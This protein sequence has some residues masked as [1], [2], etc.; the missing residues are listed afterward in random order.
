V[1]PT[2]W[3]EAGDWPNSNVIGVDPELRDPKHGDYR[4]RDGSPA[5]A[6]GCRVFPS[7]GSGSFVPAARDLAA[8]RPLT[9][10]RAGGRS[11]AT[12][13]GVVDAD[14]VWDA[15]T[16]RVMCDVVVEDGVTLEVAAGTR[17]EFQGCFGLDVHGRLL[18][19]G[20]PTEPVVF[21]TDE[22]DLYHPDTT[23]VGC[24]A[25]IRFDWTPA[26]NGLSRLE[27]CV[28]EYA[29]ALGDEPWGG[30]LSTTGFSGLV[31]RNTVVRRCWAE[32]G[33]AV[34]VSHHAAPV[35]VGCLF[36]D[37]AAHLYGSVAYSHYAY[38]RFVSCTMVGNSILS[39]NAYD[40]T[41]AVHNHIA[42]SRTVGCIVRDNPNPYY[43]PTEL[44]EAKAYYTTYSNVEAW[45]GGVG[46]L[47]TEP[48][49][50]R[51]G[52]HPYAILSGSP[53]EN[54][55]PPDTSGLWLPAVDLSGAPRIDAGRID[56][57]C[58][59]GDA[60][61]GVG[62]P[63]PDRPRIV[64]APNPFFERVELF[65]DAPQP[66]A[67][68]VRVYSVDG[69][70]VRTVLEGRVDAGPVRLS[71]DGSTDNGRPAASGIYFVR[72]A[73]AVGQRTGRIALLR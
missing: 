6:Y 23:A 61:T 66:G 21:T 53:C 51:F 20:A 52:P 42:K 25:G 15:D 28:L 40:A 27:H 67:A 31:V 71:W 58:Y 19:V 48:D 57:G 44:H 60:D 30:A 22:P 18:A 4:P 10:H 41:G 11:S 9:T 13:G 34:F 54:A 55:G 26:A 8:A 72:A 56:M 43:E 47:D 70:L 62:E 2:P 68:S 69:R 39:G 64:C 32:R 59:E 45:S 1:I 7:S 49:F 12:V 36:E 29:K 14:T 35:F 16:V 46:M 65:L 17:V 50:V 63:P 73:G 33:G 38:P 5:E 37:N 24:W 3:S